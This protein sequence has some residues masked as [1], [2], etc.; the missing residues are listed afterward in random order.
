LTAGRGIVRCEPGTIDG[1]NEFGLDGMRFLPERGSHADRLD[2]VSAP[3]SAFITR[4]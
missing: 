4:R 1:P 2:P 3:P